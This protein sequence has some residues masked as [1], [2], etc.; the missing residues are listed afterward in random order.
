MNKQK[1]SYCEGDYTTEEY[2][3]KSQAPYKSC[4]A[5]NSGEQHASWLT[6]CQVRL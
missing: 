4:A 6:V 1:Y 3:D 5:Y 2:I